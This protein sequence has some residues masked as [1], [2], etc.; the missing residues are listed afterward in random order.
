[1]SSG[2]GSPAR[3][4]AYREER[5]M[6]VMQQLQ[7][8]HTHRPAI[9]VQDW[10]RVQRLY[11]FCRARAIDRI[12]AA[13]SRHEVTTRQRRDLRTLET[14][15]GKARQYGDDVVTSCAVTYFRSQAL[16]DARHPDFL[17]EWI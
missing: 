9:E 8:A 5:R 13:E 15:Y 4:D 1:M 11:A 6:S 2:S 16:R 10:S 7:R 14:M 17:G 12:I 3:N